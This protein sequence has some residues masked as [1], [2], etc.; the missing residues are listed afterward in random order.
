MP[1]LDQP[2]EPPRTSGTDRLRHKSARSLRASLLAGL[3]SLAL[4]VLSTFLILTCFLSRIDPF[5]HPTLVLYLAT[6]VPAIPFLA[7]ACWLLS[8]RHLTLLRMAD[9]KEPPRHS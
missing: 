3:L 8:L 4:L 2:I 9:E 7:L 6:A 5:A 1:H